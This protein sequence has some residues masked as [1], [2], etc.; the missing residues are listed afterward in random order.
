MTE[1]VT[2]RS[3]L[4]VTLSVEGQRTLPPDVQVTLYRIAQEAVNNIVKHAGASQAT[5][6]LRL[7]PEKVHLLIED[8]GSGF[9]P[10]TV[11]PEHLGLGIMR[12]RAEAIGASLEIDSRVG[13]GT[14]IAVVWT[15]SGGKE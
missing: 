1:A 6:S 3:R 2:G 4:P 13:H 7:Q 8:D 12:E 9:D 14:R 10:E 5:V 15:D 11:S